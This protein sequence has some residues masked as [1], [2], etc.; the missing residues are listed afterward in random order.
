M[1]LIVVLYPLVAPGSWS[2]RKLLDYVVGVVVNILLLVPVLVI[3]SYQAT[4]EGQDF[5][6]GDKHAV[7]Y[8]RQRRQNEA[9]REH[10][11]SKDA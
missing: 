2:G 11:A 4:S 3:D 1:I 9:R 10:R 7:V 6:E 8:L 5:A